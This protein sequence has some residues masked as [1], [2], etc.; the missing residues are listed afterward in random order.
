MGIPA[1]KSWLCTG[2]L[3][4]R[5][6]SIF[7]LSIPTSIAPAATSDAAASP[8]RYGLA[9]RYRAVPHY[10]SQPVQTRTA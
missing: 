2:R 3:R 5:T 10:R 7:Q 9:A 6:S 1:R 8:V 4:F